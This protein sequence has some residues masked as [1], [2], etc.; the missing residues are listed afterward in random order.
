MPLYPE[1]RDWVQGV[2]AGLT[3]LSDNRWMMPSDHLG[4]ILSELGIVIE[5]CI[6]GAVV[7]MGC[8]GGRTNLRLA[9]FLQLLGEGPGRPLHAY[10]SFEGFPPLTEEDY[11]GDIDG[12][13]KNLRYREGGLPKLFVDW[14]NCLPSPIVH[15]GFFNEQDTT[16]PNPIAFALI[17]CDTHDSVL[18]CLNIVWPRLAPCGAV[19]VHDYNN[20]MWPGV[21]KACESY[22][23]PR[24][25]QIE[26]HRVLLDSMLVVTKVWSPSPPPNLP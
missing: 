22:L 17:D 21:S 25:D 1:Q 26:S 20:S 13:Y 10:D 14:G 8:A 15:S 5:R 4:A 12:T 11:P 18:I 24:N 16:H 6:T 19:I 7:E 3:S 2:I 23:S 9:A